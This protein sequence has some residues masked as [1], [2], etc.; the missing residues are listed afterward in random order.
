MCKVHTLCIPRS[1][2]RASNLVFGHDAMVSG[3]KKHLLPIQSGRR[4]ASLSHPY[5]L[6]QTHHQPPLDLPSRPSYSQATSPSTSATPSDPSPPPLLSFPSSWCT[7]PPPHHSQRPLFLSSPSFPPPHS[8]S[9]HPSPHHSQAPLSLSFSSHS[10]PPP[11][12]PP[13]HNPDNKAPF[14]A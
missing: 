4:N 14:P 6:L 8:P 10:P 12:S 7:H 1:P 9:S 5:L 2:S 3:T 13:S 11:P